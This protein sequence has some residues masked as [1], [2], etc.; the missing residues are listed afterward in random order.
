MADRARALLFVALAVG[1]VTAI[2]VPAV[3]ALIPECAFR[4]LTGLYCPGCGTRRAMLALVRGDVLEALHQNAF[5]VVVV[6]PVLV[7]IVRDALEAFGVRLWPRLRWPPGLVWAFGIAVVV[8]WIARNLPFA[9]F[10]YLA[11]H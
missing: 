7:S 8:F 4:S 11:P 6:A 2:L 10:T 3:G 5:A 1:A 9:P